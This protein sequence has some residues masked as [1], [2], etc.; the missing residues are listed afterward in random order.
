LG[1]TGRRF[2][3]AAFFWRGPFTEEVPKPM[4]KTGP[5]GRGLEGI[6]DGFL[7]AFGI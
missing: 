5:F 4:R 7:K 6:I 2:S 3:W 1:I